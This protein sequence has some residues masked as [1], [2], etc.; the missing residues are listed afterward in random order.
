MYQPACRGGTLGIIFAKFKHKS[1]YWEAPQLIQANFLHTHANMN[2][3]CRN[4]A[5]ALNWNVAHNVKKTRY[6]ICFALL[7]VP[8]IYIARL[9]QILVLITLIWRYIML[10]HGDSYKTV[11]IY[12]PSTVASRL[13]SSLKRVDTINKR[14]TE[15]TESS[16]QAC[17][18]NFDNEGRNWTIIYHSVTMCHIVFTLQLIKEHQLSRSNETM[19]RSNFIPLFCH[20][21]QIVLSWQLRNGEQFSRHKH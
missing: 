17:V 16:K 2:T 4:C 11:F 6:Y 10:C 8:L 7:N 15:S 3:K 12:A 9:M 5:T 1:S 19:T 14:I 21:S 18:Q 20:L 13:P